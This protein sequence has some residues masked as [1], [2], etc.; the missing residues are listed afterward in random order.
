VRTAEGVELHMPIAGPAPRMLAYA[1]DALLLWFC[2]FVFFVLL[3]LLMPPLARWAS[4]LIPDWR[5]EELERHPERALLPFVLLFMII[6]YF[7]ELLYFV[8][9]EAVTGGGS[10]GKR[11]VG[12]RVVRLDGLKVDLR[13]SWIRNLVR[14]ADVLP[15]TYVV[16]LTSMLVSARGQRLGDLAAGTLVVRLDAPER[17]AKLSLPPELP[18]LALSREQLHRLGGRE[19]ALVRGTLRRVKDMQG[20]RRA[21][22]IREASTALCTSLGLDPSQ[23]DDPETFLRRLW[24][25]MQQERRG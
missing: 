17:A 5:G 23:L 25:T 16:G 13:A 1:I 11:L 19:R 7:G 6:S 9:W 24:L 20:E 2:L 12:L 10:P 14:A 3:F 22:L 8:F 15:S 4:E 18:P 21:Q